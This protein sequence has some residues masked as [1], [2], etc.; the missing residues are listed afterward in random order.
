MTTVMEN[1]YVVTQ[2][3]NHKVHISK[4]GKAIVNLD[5]KRELSGDELSELAFWINSIQ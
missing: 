3:G 2:F 1:G 5:F 4:F